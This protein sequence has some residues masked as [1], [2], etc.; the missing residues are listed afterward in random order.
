MSITKSI[1]FLFVFMIFAINARGAGSPAGKGALFFKGNI[2]FS[3]RVA[4]GPLSDD[5]D[6]YRIGVE[7][8]YLMI[9]DFGIGLRYDYDR[10]DRGNNR[11]Y[12]YA[13]GP[14]VTIIPGGHNFQP[15]Q[16]DNILP[17]F[18]GI[19]LYLMASRTDAVCDE[20]GCTFN[21]YSANTRALR[22]F[23]GISFFLAKNV[24][25]NAEYDI[26][27]YN[28]DYPVVYSGDVV[29]RE[30]NGKARPAQHSLSLGLGA[31]LW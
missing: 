7:A 9:N 26:R 12:I 16:G 19:L 28:L 29:V 17:Y 23:L 30:D 3:G 11:Q 8:N 10:T 24:A 27:W 22:L 25:L 5:E 2:N 4:D 13:I 15:G 14:Q 18:G 21:T 20:A 1:P 6:T 31:Y